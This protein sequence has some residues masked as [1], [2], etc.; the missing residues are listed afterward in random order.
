MSYYEVLNNTD[1]EDMFSLFRYVNNVADGLFFPLILLA[2]FAITLIG[3]VLT[4]KP[5]YRGFTYASFVCSILSILLVLMNFLNKQYMYL[6]F[7]LVAIGLLW[8]RLA[9]APS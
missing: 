3:S 5:A 4:G 1:T 8:I 6:S 2:I 7:F 9:E